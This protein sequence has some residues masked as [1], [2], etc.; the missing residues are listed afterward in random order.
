MSKRITKAQLQQELDDLA[1]NYAIV[2][3]WNKRLLS[4]VANLTDDLL[5]LQAEMNTM[6]N[7]RTVFAGVAVALCIA[8][9]ALSH[10]IVDI[11]K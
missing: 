6:W 4:R 10:A 5:L 11:L 1:D 7:S 3:R 9:G 8:A 2:A